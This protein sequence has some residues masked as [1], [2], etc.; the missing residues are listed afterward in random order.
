MKA[1]LI[2]EVEERGGWAR[3][4]DTTLNFGVQH[5]RGLQML[6]Y[7]YSIQGEYEV[8]SSPGSEHSRLLYAQDL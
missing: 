6:S 7:T 2:A 4:W 3:L 5:T 8:A 1:P